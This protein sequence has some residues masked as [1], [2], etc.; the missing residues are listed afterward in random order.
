RE[1]WGGAGRGGRGWGGAAGRQGEGGQHGRPSHRV[2]SSVDHSC[3]VHRISVT[4]SPNGLAW[5]ASALVGGATSTTSTA[6]QLLRPSSVPSRPRCSSLHRTCHD[7]SETWRRL[8]T[9]ADT[10]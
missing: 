5:M 10:V 3:F 9:A 2:A 6:S 8:V 4:Y 7:R 1:G